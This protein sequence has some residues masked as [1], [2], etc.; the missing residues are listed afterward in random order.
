M[1][2]DVFL[3]VDDQS[4]SKTTIRSSFVDGRTVHRIPKS[5][6]MAAMA[7]ASKALTSFKVADRKNHQEPDLKATTA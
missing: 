2:K 5:T 7:A 6:Y 4:K 1:K 3:V